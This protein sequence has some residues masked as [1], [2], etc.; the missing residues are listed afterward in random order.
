MLIK[1]V[2]LEYW[3]HYTN[4]SSVDGRTV[5]VA[6]KT[7]PRSH[8]GSEEKMIHKVHWFGPTPVLKVK[9]SAWNWAWKQICSNE[10]CTKQAQNGRP[11]GPQH[12]ESLDI[13]GLQLHIR[14][15]RVIQPGNN[16]AR[17]DFS[18]KEHSWQIRWSWSKAIQG[19]V[20][21][22]TWKSTDSSSSTPKLWTCCFWGG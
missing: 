5:K 3:C 18:W 15:I 2:V 20:V 4:C 10:A 1:G 17:F 16:R 8:A 13:P 11:Y 19:T 6:L 7:E 22:F 12:S 14:H 9:A 21:T